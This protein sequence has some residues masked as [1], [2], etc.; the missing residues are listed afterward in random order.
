MHGHQDGPVDQGR[1]MWEGGGS[2]VEDAEPGAVLGRLVLTRWG[3][4]FLDSSSSSSRL[5]SVVRI[6][7]VHE[8]PSL[9]R[10][11][12]GMRLVKGRYSQRP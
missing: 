6:V 7:E 11:Q 12:H 4:E 3:Q 1:N 2:S 10:C 5:V 8:G 9:H